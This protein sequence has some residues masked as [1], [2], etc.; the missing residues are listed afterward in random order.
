MLQNC[1]IKPSTF[2]L[3]SVLWCSA[4]AAAFSFVENNI[5]ELSSMAYKSKILIPVLNNKTID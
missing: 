1:W 3:K 5:S 2:F 4:M